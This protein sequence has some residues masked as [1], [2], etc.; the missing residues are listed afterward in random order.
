MPSQV[1][2]AF[3]EGVQGVQAVPHVAGSVSGTHAE[4]QRWYPVLQMNPHVVPSHVDVACAGAA[5][6]VHDVPHDAMS[7]SAEQVRPHRW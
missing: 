2:V 7:L 1:A 3:A 4:P 5:H 6:G